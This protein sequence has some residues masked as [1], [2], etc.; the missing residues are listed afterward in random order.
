METPTGVSDLVDLWV[1]KI[2]KTMILCARSTSRSREE[3]M[4]QIKRR[5][6]VNGLFIL[7]TITRFY[8]YQTWPTHMLLRNS[9]GAQRFVGFCSLDCA[10]RVLIGWVGKLQSYDRYD[11]LRPYMT[12]TGLFFKIFF[13]LRLCHPRHSLRPSMTHHLRPKFYNWL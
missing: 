8:D 1:I 2:K 11:Q 13:L 4:T 9:R 7:V 5:E 12:E 10:F 3:S 6:H